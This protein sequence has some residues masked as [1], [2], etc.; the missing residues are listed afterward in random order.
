MAN[1]SILLALSGFRYNGPKGQ[2]AFNP[3]FR[4]ENFRSFFSTAE[5]WGTYSQVRLQ[6][7]QVS[8]LNLDYGKL[9]LSHFSVPLPAG[10]KV[11]RLSA[12]IGRQI[13]NAGVSDGSVV[14][15]LPNLDIKS[16]QKLTVKAELS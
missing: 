8:E 2:L 6:N 9:R 7:S 10:A 12:N 3:I 16:G 1:W 14:V 15:K 11:T 13:Y 5:G 4:P